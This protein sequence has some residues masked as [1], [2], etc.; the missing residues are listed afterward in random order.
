M[1]RRAPFGLIALVLLALLVSACGS[2]GPSIV[3]SEPAAAESDALP[4]ASDGAEATADDGVPE[5]GTDLSACEIVAPA[6]VEAALDLEPGAVADGELTES[7][8]TL[9]PGHSECRYGGDWGGLVV[10]LTPEDGANLYDAA[11]GAYEDASDRE[12]TG[13]D[14]AFYS[15]DATRGFAW[16]G[17]VAVMLQITHLAAEADWD[18]VT[19]ALMQA[20]MDKV[21]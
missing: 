4:T 18:A 5:P 14:G 12:V 11:R 1:P 15:A 16:K 19:T 2:S 9:S 8:T 17:N 6:D 3:A 10:S 13:A 7:P 20:S 21:A